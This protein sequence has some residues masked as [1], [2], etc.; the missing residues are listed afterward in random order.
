MRKRQV[1]SV[2]VFTLFLGTSLVAQSGSAWAGSSKPKISGFKASPKTIKTGNGTVILTAKKVSHATRCVLTSSPLLAG[3]P[4]DVEPCSSID[5]VVELPHDYANAAANYTFTLT[6]R[7]AALSSSKS[8]KVK[9]EPGE[10][11]FV[12]PSTIT[13]NESGT[14]DNAGGSDP[15]NLAFEFD[16]NGSCVGTDVCSY[17]ETSITGSGSEF[18]SPPGTCEQTFP[19]N[20]GADDLTA[21]AATF[22]PDANEIEHLSFAASTGPIALP[23]PPCY[24]SLDWGLQ[25]TYP[26]GDV[27]NDIWVPGATSF[28]ATYAD[29]DTTGTIN[30]YFSYT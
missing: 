21:F 8:L 26:A 6:A 15:F 19:I 1:V 3:L 5:Q 24:T 23:S 13:G 4:M 17:N 29:G 18:D 9:V 20:L 28:S 16:Q 2:V 14:T 25:H 27:S 12:Y 11:G 10:G 7:M 22:D 30:F